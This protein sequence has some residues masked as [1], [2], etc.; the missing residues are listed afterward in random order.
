M[1]LALTL[2]ALIPASTADAS[3][4]DLYRTTGSDNHVLAYGLASTGELFPVA[5]SPVAQSG[6]PQGVALTPDGR[7]LYVGLGGSGQIAA[8]SVA[9]DGS[10]SALSGSPF[11][12]GGGARGL[13]VSPDGRSLYVVSGADD[14]VY[15]HAINADGSLSPVSAPT[16]TG[17]SSS[18]AMV[19]IAPGGN[20][21]Y[22]STFAASKVLGFSI[23][24]DGSLS[25][26]PGSPYSS[27]AGGVGITI[28]P[29]GAHLYVASTVTST[30]NGFSIGADGS[31]SPVPGSP[32]QSGPGTR[33]IAVTADGHRLYTTNTAIGM[34]QGTWGYDVAANG[35]LT[36]VAGNPFTPAAQSPIAMAPDSHHLYLGAAFNG[37]TNGVTI[38][39]AGELTPVPGDPYPSSASLSDAWQMAISPDQ[40]PVAAFATA[41]GVAG[42]PSVFDAS[43]S[44][45]GEGTVARYDWDFGDGSTASTGALTTHAYRAPGTYR[46]TLT[47]TDNEG[48]STAFV[49]TGQTAMCNGSPLARTTHDVVVADT[50]PPG[51]KLSGKRK[52]KL[53]ATVSVGA[54]CD[55]PC[56]AT[57]S[58]KVVV[59]PGHAH[60]HRGSKRSSAG[61]SFKLKP[62]SANLAT[63][64]TGTLKLKLTKTIRK[65][66]TKALEAGGSASANLSVKATDGSGNAT[67]LTRK[68]R[69]VL[70]R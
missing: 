36:P 13:A 55:E 19:A 35:S 61:H 48:C 23:A 51:L 8:F 26:L 49:F 67:T 52:Q 7:F 22:V 2:L 3:S 43:A 63:A 32:F 24:A 40:A 9:A 46:V 59:I 57:A 34:G 58:G 56:T 21:L 62:K 60:G 25:P 6:S 54:T 15:R 50:K 69:L 41:P 38:G 5:G 1:F 64:A 18:P 12:S 31:L 4:R 16:S 47:V 14:A 37:G 17:A 68:V 27:G 70:A 65:P 10:L 44:R 66:A 33:G 30:V 42:A 53:G 28:T 29:D 39:P 20:R 11:A 45:D